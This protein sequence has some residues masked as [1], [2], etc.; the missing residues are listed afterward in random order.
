MRIPKILILGLK[1][2]LSDIVQFS[3]IILIILD[4]F[5]QF[6]TF[7]KEMVTDRPMDQLKDRRT[8]PNME[9]RGRI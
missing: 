8:H 3:F 4:Q 1:G 5:H 2:F 6:V 9:M 7:E